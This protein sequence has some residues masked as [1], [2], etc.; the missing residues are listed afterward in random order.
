MIFKKY[1][2]Y[3][4]LFYALSLISIIVASF[5]DLAIDKALNNPTDIFSVWFYNTGEMPSRLI[6]PL[7]GTV[8]YLTYKTK[9]EKILGLVFSLGGSIYL[10]IHLG[11]YF[12]KEP[13]N[14]VY[15]GIYGLGLGIC[16]LIVSKFINIPD[17]K[18]EIL[19]KISYYVIAIMFIQ[20]GIVEGSKFLWGRVR[21]RDLLKAGSFDAFTPWYHLNGL[22]GNKSFPSGHTGGAAVSYTMLF[23]PYISK[24]WNDKKALSFIIPLVYS[25]TVAFT[26]LVMGAHYLSDVTAG[27]FIAF[28]TV[29][30]AIKI[31]EKKNANLIDR[32]SVLVK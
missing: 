23:L 4:V 22:T 18:K 10:G 11:M 27:G 21:F 7:A 24:K 2:P 5:Y 6:L 30:V 20:T 1:K 13:N 9:L 3:I 14:Y 19:R 31:F 26:R 15:G 28:T 32:E 12:F 29:I 16:I 17:D 8:I 25:S